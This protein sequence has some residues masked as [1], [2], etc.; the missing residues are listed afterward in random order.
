MPTLYIFL[1]LPGTGKTTLSQ[2][3]AKQISAVYLRIDTIEQAMR[4]LCSID[5]Q[6]EGYCLAYRIAAD[7]LRLGISVVADSCNPI[8]LTRR[9]WENVA[10]QCHAKYV[11]I[12]VICS[13]RSEHRD[14]IETRASSIPGLR[15]PTWQDVENRDFQ[16][17]SGNRIV[18]DTSGQ[19]EKESCDRLLSVLSNI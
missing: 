9:A 7:N 14:R 19:S 1:G 12:E 8:E 17:W 16:P 5:V 18:I 10:L 3:L 2:A 13:D 11:N 6:S 15:L 4:D